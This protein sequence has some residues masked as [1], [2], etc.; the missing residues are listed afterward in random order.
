MKKFRA[1]D[2]ISQTA[3][4]NCHSLWYYLARLIDSFS[5]PFRTARV[6]QCLLILV[7]LW[8]HSFHPMGVLVDFSHF[9]I[10]FLAV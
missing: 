3:F 7:S 4:T 8:T 6:S 10:D 5:S 2:P 9:E 1:L